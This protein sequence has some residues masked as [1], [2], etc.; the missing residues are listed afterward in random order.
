MVVA[1]VPRDENLADAMTKGVGSETLRFHVHGVG[2]EIRRD[3][4][5]L[6]P[7]MEKS[8]ELE[9]QWNLSHGGAMFIVFLIV[10]ERNVL[11]GSNVGMLSSVAWY[12][13]T[14][15]QMQ[16]GKIDPMCH[17]TIS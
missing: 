3:R 11:W 14:F 13:P 9:A 10:G 2:A 12:V 15:R 17:D 4:H 7:K 6:A 16:I 1:K 8:D 5:E